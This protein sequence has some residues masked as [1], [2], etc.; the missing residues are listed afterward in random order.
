M[1][2]HSTILAWRI[3]WTEEAAGYSPWGHKELDM[4]EHLTFSYFF[5][6]FICVSYV[7][8]YVLYFARC[9]LLNLSVLCFFLLCLFFA[10]S[11]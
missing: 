8:F 1:A 7:K 6:L 5:S 2:I 3:S 11:S 10:L 4:T 9:F